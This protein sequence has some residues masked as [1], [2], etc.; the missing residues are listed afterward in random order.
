LLG[1]TRLVNIAVGAGNSVYSSPAGI[2]FN[3]SQ[4]TLIQFPEGRSGSY[5]IPD[6]VTSI[7]TY[8]FY[9]C[10]NLTSVT[11]PNGV[12]NVGSSAF[13]ACTGLTNITI[14]GG[15]TGIG[16]H[17]FYS[18]TGLS[19]ITIPN[20]VTNLG[21]QAFG[22]CTKLRA[23]YF[24]GNAPGG[25]S[26]VFLGDN[27][28][29]VYYLPMTTGWSALFGG[30]S[31]VL[32]YTC[33]TNS[34]TIWITGYFGP[35]GDVTIPQTLGG[36]P[37][38]SLA[39][40]AFYA[41]TSLTGVT[42]P[43]S[44]TN[45]GNCAFD[46][47]SSLT[48]ITIGSGVI[49][50]GGGAFG[51]CTRLIAITVSTNNPVYGSAGGVLCNK[52]LSTLIQFPAGRAGSYTVP[53]TVSN[54]G[55]SAFSGCSSLASITLPDNVIDIGNDAFESCFSLTSVTIGHGVTRIG[56]YA[57]TGCSGLPGITIPDNVV[58]L[59]EGAFNWCYGL[60]N[61]TIGHG[62]TRIGDYAFSACFTLAD[63]TI[64]N[65]V[66]SI[67][68]G[69][70][71]WCDN[72]NSATIGTG[73]TNLAPYAFGSCFSLTEI[74]FQG[75]APG[76]GL[77][78]SVFDGDPGT[79]YYLTGTTG[80]HSPFDGLPAVVW[81]S[82][83]QISDI[84]FGMQTNGFGF[85]ITGPANTPIVVEACTNLACATWIPLQTCCVTNGSIYFCDEQ[86]TNHP[87]RYY[88]VR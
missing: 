77:D 48:N 15:V 23:V 33:T 39:T 11:I 52:S 73:V 2:L 36:L 84:G 25:D 66:V 81:V 49:S 67:G 41:R 58:T 20:N 68:E 29:A 57:F 45:V 56:D 54:I 16:D 79:I 40:N 46:S 38:T 30:R 51:D 87:T 74:Y 19:S 83:V 24:L 71:Y 75:D 7:G 86:W 22:N 27:N 64:P 85:T 32:L 88:R 28:A 50:I 55:D 47:C 3:K 43:N 63:I 72:L 37:V 76:A 62:V 65:W 6:G 12:T 35:G 13:Y 31:A 26:T 61:V 4:T 34:G 70:F 69:A 10:T 18:C 80:W 21:S 14:G 82:E 5:T 44:I 59:G 9:N 53:G 42:I 8:G 78:T 1:C 60:T 17:A